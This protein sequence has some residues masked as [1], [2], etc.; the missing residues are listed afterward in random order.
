AQKRG[1]IQ[2]DGGTY[3]IYQ[4]QRVNQPSIVGTATF[5]QFWS[6]RQSHRVGGTITIGNHF[7]AWTDNGLELGAHDYMIMATEGYQ[8]TGSSAITVVEVGAEEAPYPDEPDSVN[9]N[10]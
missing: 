2:S 8:S 4:T 5:Y 10:N 7:D 9:P 6:V 1:S 3:D